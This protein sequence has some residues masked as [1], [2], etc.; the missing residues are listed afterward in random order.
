MTPTAAIHP[1]T[2]NFAPLLGLDV[3][4]V[5]EGGLADLLIVD[6]DPTV[7]ISLLQKPDKRRAVIKGGRF[8][9]INPG[10]YP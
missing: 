7:D 6:G 8:A 3:G 1:A 10:I 5:R 4:E 9:Y 2:R